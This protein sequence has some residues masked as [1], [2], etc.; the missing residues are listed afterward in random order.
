M[1]LNILFI[2]EKKDYVQRW[3]VLPIQLPFTDQ[4]YCY[5]TTQT[6]PDYYVIIKHKQI[7]IIMFS[8]DTNSTENERDGEITKR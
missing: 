4:D 6:D 1:S 2:L 3:F 7:Q 8:Y 5:H